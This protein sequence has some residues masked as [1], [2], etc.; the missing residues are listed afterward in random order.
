MKNTR[1]ALEAIELLSGSSIGLDLEAYL[2]EK[3]VTKKDPLLEAA[4]RIVTEIYKIAH[5]ENSRDCKH[6]TW[7]DIK[8]NVIKEY[9]V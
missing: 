9:N 6:E 3:R 2:Y 4:A 1:K 5:A 7:E 8:Y